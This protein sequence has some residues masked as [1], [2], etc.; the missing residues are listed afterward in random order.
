AVAERT[1]HSRYPVVDGDLDHVIG[2]VHMKDLFWQLKEME[3][4]PQ[5]AAAA[6]ER[7]NPMIAGRDMNKKPPA[8]GAQFLT[9]IARQV[10]YVPETAKVDTLLQEFQLKRIHMAMVV[11]EYGS[12]TGLVTFENVIEE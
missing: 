9:S 4:S 5:E 12:T 11:D 2:I 1:A 8:T 3:M 7:R 10:L 6:A